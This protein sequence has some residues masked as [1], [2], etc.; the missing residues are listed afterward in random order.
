MPAMTKVSPR[1]YVAVAAVIAVTSA[2]GCGHSKPSNAT[3]A[4]TGI[5]SA[6]AEK[7]SGPTACDRTAGSQGGGPWTIVMPGTLCGL[8]ADTSANARRN[9]QALVQTET[10]SFSSGAHPGIGTAQSSAFGSWVTPIGVPV[11]RSISATGFTGQFNPSI[12]LKTLE[13]SGP[14]YR[15]ISPGPHGG[16]MACRLSSGGSE[17]CA[18][19]TTT[20]AGA[21]T[22]GD[23]SGQLTKGSRAAT[24]AT[25]IRDALE[26]PAR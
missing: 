24:I 18:F 25:E 13:T 2:V 14:A 26:A 20:T 15:K 1:W 4:P 22:L 12:A 9:G 3:P 5:P 17:S 8:P 19:A 11:Y 21:F 7:M 6:V 16:V 23:T 10:I